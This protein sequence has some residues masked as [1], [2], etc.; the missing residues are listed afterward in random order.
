MYD[1][2]DVARC[3][4][5]ERYFASD[6]LNHQELCAECHELDPTPTSEYCDQCDNEAVENICG[7]DLCD[8]CLEHY[9]Y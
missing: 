1:D 2:E 4:E 5:C 9:H 3:V 6:D 7:V 8:D